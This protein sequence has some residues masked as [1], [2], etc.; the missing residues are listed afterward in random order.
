MKQMQEF[1]GRSKKQFSPLWSSCAARASML[2]CGKD[3]ITPFYPSRRCSEARVGLFNCQGRSRKHFS[4]LWCS[5]E[6]RAS[7]F[8]CRKDMIT[9][10]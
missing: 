10:F 8:V 2:M 9:Q 4:P 1:H 7:L 6:A 3:L 5:Y